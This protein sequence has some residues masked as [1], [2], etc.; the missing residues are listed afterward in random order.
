MMLLKYVLKP[1]QD[2]H[3]RL[4]DG[5][6]HGVS[7]EQV[8]YNVHEACSVKLQIP[9]CKSVNGKLT[10]TSYLNKPTTFMTTRNLTC[11]C[12]EVTLEQN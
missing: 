7:H 11:N 6:L 3:L 2:T 1:V 5:Y 4:P 9:T 10:D 8:T 12:I